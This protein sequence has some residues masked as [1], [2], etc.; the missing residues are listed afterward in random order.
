[1]SFRESLP[2]VL[3]LLAF[4]TI[5]GLGLPPGAGAQSFGPDE[6]IAFIG[7]GAM[8]GPDGKEIEPT[9]EFL[10]RAQD[11]YETEM[12]RR[13]SPEAQQR[14]K[15]LSEALDGEIARMGAGEVDRP[16]R[17]LA[18]TVR[19]GQ[20]AAGAEIPP[21][22][23]GKLSL[24]QSELNRRIG[25]IDPTLEPVQE[26]RNFLEG[27]ISAPQG[28]NVLF[29]TVNQGAAYIAECISSGV[30]IPP[31][32]N[33]AGWTPTG[34]LSNAQE[35]ISVGEEGRPYLFT[36]TSPP[37]T[38]IALP[39]FYDNGNGA[40][41]GEGHLDTDPNTPDIKLLG[42][43]CLGT[44]TSKACFWDNSTPLPDV[45]TTFKPSFDID[46]AEVVP[47]AAFN[48]G[49]GLLGAQGGVCTECHA[50]EN[51]FVIHPFTALDPVAFGADVFGDDWY[52]PLVHPTWPQN[53][54]PTNI[55]ATIPSAGRCDSCH[56]QGGTG[57]RFPLIST[58]IGLGGYCGAVL[59]QAIGRT[60]PPGNP[61]DFGLC[62]PC[63]GPPGA[64]LG[65][66]QAGPAARERSDRLQRGRARLR[67]R[68][69]HRRA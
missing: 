21:E 33:E 63:L 47:L 20:L 5:A 10:E 6:P 19:I 24:I 60:M 64:L 12:E 54:G 53:A 37:G 43:I 51:S 30:P 11:Y 4:L 67:L 34:A 55:L 65:P 38:C 45:N 49:A 68:Q 62:R 48:G 59:N 14:V 56:Q 41:D 69:G 13:A 29:S 7:H 17:L 9:L 25:A 23:R 57:G 15:D 26:L 66:G 44:Q 40:G 27:R 46:A 50:G 58:T 39:R 16:L 35:F 2:P 28:G 22:V 1:M 8:F 52:D 31:G 32:W 42:I 18:Q 36:S 3:R 61:G